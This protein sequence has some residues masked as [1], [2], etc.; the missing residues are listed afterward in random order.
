M[1]ALLPAQFQAAAAAK[2][3]AA[4]ARFIEP[5][6]LVRATLFYKPL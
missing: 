4:Y 5:Q 2:L 6:V 3:P 1:A